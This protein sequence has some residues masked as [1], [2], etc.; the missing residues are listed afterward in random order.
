MER[1]ILKFHNIRIGLNYPVL[2]LV[3]EEEEEKQRQTNKTKQ[4]QWP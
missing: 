1:P 4:T 2:P 3:K